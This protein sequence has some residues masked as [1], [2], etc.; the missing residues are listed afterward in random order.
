MRSKN[1]VDASLVS[2]GKQVLE[3]VSANT[4]GS[5]SEEGNNNVIEVYPEEESDGGDEGSDG[6]GEENN[7]K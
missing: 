6:V 3:S 7:E 1:I 2:P 4:H 5:D